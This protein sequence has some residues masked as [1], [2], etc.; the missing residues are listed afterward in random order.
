MRL[1]KKHICLIFVLLTGTLTV[2][3]QDNIIIKTSVDS[4][5]AGIDIPLNIVIKGGE[6]TDSFQLKVMGFDEALKVYAPNVENGEYIQKAGLIPE[7][8]EDTD[9]EISD[10]GNWKG[11]GSTLIPGNSN[12]NQIKIKIWDFGQFYIMPIR[13]VNKNSKIDTIYPENPDLYPEI[14]VFAG[15]NP[16]DTIPQIAPIK[17]ILTE[18]KTWEDYMFIIISTIVLI[19]IILMLIF[20][21]KIFINKKSPVQP[22]KKIK[23]SP[24]AHIIALEKLNKL[25]AE[26]LWKQGEIKEFQ[27]Q[28]TYILR[29]YLENRYKIQALEQTSGE[30]VHSLQKINLDN[31]D[32]E[33]IQNILQI[34]DMVK[35]AKAKP[36]EDINETFLNETIDFV[37]RTKL[38]TAQ[39]S[40]NR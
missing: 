13:I 11:K 31:K 14:S 15:L 32:I 33:I 10:Y 17:D 16:R 1:I 29:E 22:P 24:P 37:Q 38:V 35:F 27:S 6:K 19:L 39:N 30:I 20:L 23:K 40:S 9:F 2:Y 34:A 5:L 4:T 7:D 18:K 28:L 8:I 36:G 25:K 21:P 12:S 26:K 3:G